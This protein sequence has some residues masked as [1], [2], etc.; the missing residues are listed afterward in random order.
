M[1]KRQ[2]LCGGSG[3]GWE[4]GKAVTAGAVLKQLEKIEGILSVEA[5]T[6]TDED[7]NITGEKIILKADEFPFLTGIQIENRRDIK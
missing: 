1:Y 6:L 4:Q 2:V 7:L 3:N 5:V